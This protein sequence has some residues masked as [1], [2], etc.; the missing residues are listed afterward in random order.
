MRVINLV[1]LSIFALFLAAQLSS[2]LTPASIDSDQNNDP[3]QKYV[4]IDVEKNLPPVAYFDYSPSNPKVGD[5]VT[6]DA[7]KSYDPDGKIVEYRWSY[8]NMEAACFPVFVGYGEKVKYSWD[9][10]GYYLVTL[11]VIDNDGSKDVLQKKI[12]VDKA[13]IPPS[14][15]FS[16]SPSDPRV[17]EEVVFDASESKDDGKIVEYRWDFGD[18]KT[19]NGERIA[20]VYSSPGS[21][22]VTL[23]V[24]DD[25]GL[26]DSITKGIDIKE[27]EIDTDGDGIPDSQDPDDDNDGWSD[28]EEQEF[29]TDP[30]NPDDYPLDTD[31]DH[32]PDSID[33]DD[34]NDGVADSEDA[35]PKDPSEWQDTDG[36]GIGDNAD[37][38]DDND[39]YTDEEEINQGTDPKDP[40]SYP[41]DDDNNDNDSDDEED[42]EEN[43]QDDNEA[44]DEEND[45]GDNQDNNNNSNSE[46]DTDEGKDDET[47]EK[48]SGHSSQSKHWSQSH[49]EKET[50]QG[51]EEEQKGNDSV[52]NNS[53]E[54]EDKDVDPSYFYQENN[55]ED[56]KATEFYENIKQNSLT[57][58]PPTEDYTIYAV[59][60]LNIIALIF[61]LMSGKKK[62][63][64]GKEGTRQIIEKNDKERGNAISSKKVEI[65]ELTPR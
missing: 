37:P 63:K 53:I 14:A 42:N 25:D 33:T 28:E 10:P 24:I 13:L 35:F 52:Y 47:S 34:D 50:Y 32:I 61:F 62:R 3:K 23:T 45:S 2:G 7:S 16:F 65:I 36:D 5:L 22:V 30:K 44:G 18:G 58:S 11:V 49:H 31:D 43:N 38:D 1:V 59:I 19:G 27:Q 20:H 9:Q 12:H 64:I 15:D 6:F 55:P 56:D 17:G 41:S 4:D 57:S 21:Y 48:N 46:D 39:G 8:I 40:E 54:D 29:G 60:L 51:T 26:K